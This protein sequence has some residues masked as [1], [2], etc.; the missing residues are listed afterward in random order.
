[1]I[2]SI[3][4]ATAIAVAVR[5]IRNRLRGVNLQGGKPRSA[6]QQMYDGQ[7]RKLA[8]RGQRK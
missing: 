8:K 5:A 2:H 6:W 3:T 7:Q 4:K 1:M